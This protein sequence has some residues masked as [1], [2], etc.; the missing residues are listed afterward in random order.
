MYKSLIESFI[1][2]KKVLLANKSNT[3]FEAFNFF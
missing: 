3:N 2:A 1:E